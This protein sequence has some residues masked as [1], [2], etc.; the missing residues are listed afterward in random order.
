MALWSDGFGYSF[1]GKRADSVRRNAAPQQR[2]A[3]PMPGADLL[4]SRAG[5]A[6]GIHPR[7]RGKRA[8]ARSP[9]A[10]SVLRRGVGSLSG[11][12]RGYMALASHSR[13]CEHRSSDQSRGQELELS[14]RVSPLD[15][16]S[17]GSLALHGDVGKWRQHERNPCSRTFNAA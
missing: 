12:P 2:A 17:Q 11:V 7:L 9:N 15:H 3:E 6:G 8:H 13:G 4:V 5:L 16:T 14:H 1:R 10:V